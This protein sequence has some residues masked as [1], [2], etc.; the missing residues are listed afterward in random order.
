[1]LAWNPAWKKNLSMLA[2]LNVL[3]A[4]KQSTRRYNICILINYGKR[5]SMY[6]LGMHHMAT[7]M[8]CNINKIKRN[9]NPDN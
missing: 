9:R 8:Q 2:S 5:S 1:M 4:K 6:S 7:M 3:S